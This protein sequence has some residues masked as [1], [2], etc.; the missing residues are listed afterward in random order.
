MQKFYEDH[1]LVEFIAINEVNS[2]F[3]D[4]V[5]FKKTI[6]ILFKKLIDILYD[7]KDKSFSELDGWDKSFVHIIKFFGYGDTIPHTVITRH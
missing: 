3:S 6:D 7:N 2:G 4:H 5:D 1:E